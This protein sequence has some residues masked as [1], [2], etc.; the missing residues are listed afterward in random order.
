MPLPLTFWCTFSSPLQWLVMAILAI[1]FIALGYKRY[2]EWLYLYARPMSLYFTCGTSIAC[3]CD[4]FKSMFAKDRRKKS[5]FGVVSSSGYPILKWPS[6]SIA[7]TSSE[8]T[9]YDK[10]QWDC[11]EVSLTSRRLRCAGIT[12]EFVNWDPHVKCTPVMGWLQVDL[13][14]ERR[15]WVP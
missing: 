2:V 7:P 11:Q 9:A 8:R 5:G 3:I 14:G 1:L 12:G 4:Q 10:A 6:L 15:S 13:A